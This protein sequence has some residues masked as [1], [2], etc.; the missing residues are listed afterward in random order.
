MATVWASRLLLA[1]LLLFINV[2]WQQELQSCVGHRSLHHAVPVAFF[3]LV[4]AITLQG[5]CEEVV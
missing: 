5:T 3:P 2:L 4:W 1:G